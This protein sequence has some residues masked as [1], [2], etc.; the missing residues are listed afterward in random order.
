MAL[1]RFDLFNWPTADLFD[2]WLA[3]IR[4]P[5]PQ[6]N[7]PLAN[8]GATDVTETDKEFLVVCDTPGMTNGDVKVELKGNL[9]TISGERKE[10]HREESPDKKFYRSER[11][12]GSFT[13]SFRIP[14][15]ADPAQIKASCEHGV[16][17][18]TLPKKAAQADSAGVQI[19]IADKH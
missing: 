12:H 19:S 10:E 7:L 13:R 18:V 17:K 15:T 11:T 14:A 1:T 5:A 9:L 6:T 16:L 8:L 3:P 2:T 4:S